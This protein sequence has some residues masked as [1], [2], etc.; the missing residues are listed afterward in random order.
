M[1]SNYKPTN[2]PNQ[3]KQNQTQTKQKKQNQQVEQT[4]FLSNKSKH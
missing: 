2:K 4:V 1:N 3:T